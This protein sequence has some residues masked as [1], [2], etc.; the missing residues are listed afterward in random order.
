MVLFNPTAKYRVANNEPKYMPVKGSR[1]ELIKCLI[2]DVKPQSID[3]LEDQ[4]ACYK[5]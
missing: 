5:S 2:N 1:S 4:I 3:K